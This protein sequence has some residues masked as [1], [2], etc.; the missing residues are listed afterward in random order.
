MIAC[1]VCGKEIAKSAKTCPHCGARNKKKRSFIKFALIALAVVG[2]VIVVAIVA[3]GSKQSKQISELTCDDLKSQAEEMKLKNL[4][5]A[6][7]KILKVRDAK[8]ESRN[9]NSITCKGTAMLETGNDVS[10]TIR[11]YEED[12]DRM[13]HISSR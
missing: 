10:L 6:T 5:G 12:G 8:I 3:G 1:K 4:F 7:V 2:I 11:V 9:D 13:I